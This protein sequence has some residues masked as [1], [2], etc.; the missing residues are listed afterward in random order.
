MEKDINLT[1]VKCLLSLASTVIDMFV[2]LS[3]QRHIR[4][5]SHLRTNGES[6]INFYVLYTKV[7]SSVSALAFTNAINASGEK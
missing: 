1:Q 5:K 7:R 6:G 3:H 2:N 4:K